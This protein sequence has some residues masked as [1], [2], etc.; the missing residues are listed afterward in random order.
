MM[1]DLEFGMEE[2]GPF[3]ITG[4]CVNHI[5]DMVPPPD[6]NFRVAS[7]AMLYYVLVFSIVSSVAIN[8]MTKFLI[9]HA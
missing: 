9:S 8:R 1:L 6:E 7:Y 5:E 4:N 2:G 3:F